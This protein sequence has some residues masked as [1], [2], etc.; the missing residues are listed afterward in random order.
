MWREHRV[1]LL[2]KSCLGLMGPRPFRWFQLHCLAWGPRKGKWQQMLKWTTEHAANRWDAVYLKVCTSTIQLPQVFSLFCLV[3]SQDCVGVVRWMSLHL[4]GWDNVCDE[5]NFNLGTE[6]VRLWLNCSSW[7]REGNPF[8]SAVS[9]R[10]MG[11][12]S[13]IRWCEERT[14]NTY[15]TLSCM[16]DITTLKRFREQCQAWPQNHSRSRV[17]AFRYPRLNLFIVTGEKSHRYACTRSCGLLPASSVSKHS[18][19]LA[20]TKVLLSQE[21][22]S[23]PSNKLAGTYLLLQIMGHKRLTSWCYEYKFKVW[24]HNLAYPVQFFFKN[25]PICFVLL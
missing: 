7:F 1:Q 17:W 14:S 16:N 22:T 23:I 25:F 2:R 11:E 10:W 24:A 8:L 5:L 12:G 13:T 3:R 4:L 6:P 9:V 15:N 21:S 19:L 18:S 20:I